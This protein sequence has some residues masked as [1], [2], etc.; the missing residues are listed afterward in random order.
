M[1]YITYNNTDHADGAGSQI[2][3]I[4]TLYLCAK[5]FNIK[6]IHSPLLK[7]AYQ[8]LKCLE[9]N[10]SDDS[11]IQLYNK[12]ID[13]PS[14]IF[15]NIDNVYNVKILSTDIIKKFYNCTTNVLLVCT[16]CSVVD[17]GDVSLL[18]QKIHFPWIETSLRT[19]IIIAVHVRRGE[20]F[21]VDSDRMLPN[22]YYVD[23]MNGL[24]QIMNYH[25]IPYEFH[26]HTEC[27]TKETVITPEHHGILNR[28]EKDVIISPS[29]SH[30]EDFH[31]IQNVVYRINENPIE[32]FQELTNADILLA[33]RS[34]FSY[35]A[36]IL[37]R[38]GCVLFHPFWHKLCSDWIETRSV[39]DV[40]LNRK[41]IID[42]ISL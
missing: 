26:I 12:L 3:R 32:T 1:L 19:P 15:V 42:S 17:D 13:L 24:S 7:L 40:F 28:T 34:S 16:Y 31:D 23:I 36:A 27:V 2:Q 22:S 20:L 29:D 33:S 14:D 41:K 9:E 37:K 6:Y 21:V 30:L 8:G 39:G 4:L 18:K 35:V 25:A 38:K 10:K 11:Q 5:H